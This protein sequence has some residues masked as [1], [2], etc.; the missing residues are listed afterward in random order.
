MCLLFVLYEIAKSI[1]I[2]LSVVHVEHGIRGAESLADAEFVRAA[3]DKLAIPF[4]LVSIDCVG[5]AAEHGL[6]TEEAGRLLRYQA[7][8]AEGAD[9]I[10]VAHHKNDVAET[11]LFHLF[12]GTGIRGLASISPMR[13]DGELGKDRIIRPLLCVTRAEIED[14]LATNKIDYCTDGTNL[15]TDYS[16]NRIRNLI[17]P[18][19]TKINEQA[20]SHMC[21]TAEILRQTCDYMTSMSEKL[22]LDY[23][24]SQSDD[25]IILQAKLF[26]D[27]PEI[28][29]TSILM[30][31]LKQLTGKWKD[32]TSRHL[33]QIIELGEKQ[34][35]RHVQLPYQLEA[36]REYDTI[37]ITRVPTIKDNPKEW[38]TDVPIPL[39]VPVTGEMIL[40]TG[41]HLITSLQQRE[42]NEVIPTEP[43]TKW[44]DYDKIKND[45]FLRT[46][47]S[48][49]FLYVNSDLATQK[50]KS[51]FINEKIPQRERDHKLLLADGNHILWI[52]GYRISEGAKIDDTT[53]RVWK[54]SI[55]PSGD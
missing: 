41:D 39:E 49:D 38:D 53:N 48:G 46:R 33:H 51:Y 37:V 26:S 11:M 20:I 22:A 7:F 27:Q 54:V 42:K 10:A 31:C 18:E 5:Y 13:E 6:T 1:D 44:F 24:T 35:G 28:I 29:V 45:V 12:R 25:T 43:Y 19:A 15:T 17:L 32:I 16:R 47:Q 36:R 23:V 4:R 52:P 34:S 2:K 8:R 40:P 3:C 50:L 21:D 30:K 14:Y 55:I 9:K